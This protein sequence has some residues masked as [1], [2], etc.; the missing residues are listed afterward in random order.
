[1][2]PSRSDAFPELAPAG[3]WERLADPDTAPGGGSAAALAA[4]MAAALVAKAARHSVATWPDA[5]GVAA[6]AGSLG[7]RC[8]D[9]AV[10]DAIAF[11]AAL[12]ALERGTQVELALAETVAELLALGEAAADVAELAARTAERCDGTFR[13]D[14][15]AAALLAESAARG[16]AAL[17]TANLTVAE[18]DARLLQARRSAEA[19]LAAGRRALEAGP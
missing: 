3:L 12:A 17:V 6:Q 14:A 11:A 19:A 7:E 18:G 2:S 8:S 9:L 1:V 5:A 15:V 16:A 10:S 13:G 4:W